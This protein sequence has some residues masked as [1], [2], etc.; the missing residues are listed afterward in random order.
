MQSYINISDL[1]IKGIF[2]ALFYRKIWSYQKKA[3]PLHSLSNGNTQNHLN[4]KHPRSS[5][6]QGKSRG[7]EHPND[8]DYRS[9]CEIAER[10]I[11]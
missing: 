7:I 8:A 9:M 6:L 2:F 5:W 3:V 4:G 10:E 1:A 11:Q